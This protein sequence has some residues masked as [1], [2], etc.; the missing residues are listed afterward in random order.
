MFTDRH[1]VLLGVAMSLSTLAA[2]AASVPYWQTI[3]V[4]TP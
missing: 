4:L 2:I 1:G 3:G